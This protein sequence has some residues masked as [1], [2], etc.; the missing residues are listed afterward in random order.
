VIEKGQVWRVAGQ[1]RGAMCEKTEVGEEGAEGMLQEVL[2][3]QKTGGPGLHFNALDECLCHVGL[4]SGRLWE[5]ATSLAGRWCI[6][7]M[8]MVSRV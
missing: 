2:G 6:A 5:F 1:K 7:H 3:Q 4:L 8:P